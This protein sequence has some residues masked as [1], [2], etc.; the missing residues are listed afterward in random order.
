MESSCKKNPKNEEKGLGSLPNAILVCILSLF[1]TKVV[2]RTSVLCQLWRYLWTEVTAVEFQLPF[3]NQSQPMSSIM[4]RLASPTLLR[5][6][7]ITNHFDTFS[8]RRCCKLACD[9]KVEENLG[10]IGLFFYSSFYLLTYIRKVVCHYLEPYAKMTLTGSSCV[11][12]FLLFLQIAPN[13][14]EVFV[15][16]DYDYITH[17]VVVPEFIFNNLDC[18]NIIRLQGNS[19]EVNLVG[20]IIKN[21]IGLNHH[22][23][24]VYVDDAVE[25]EDARPETEFKLY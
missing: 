2:V 24:R 4:S 14:K 5:F 11:N 12:D 1:P 23:M 17:S 10:E 20:Y 3:S 15:I 7:V 18:V 9:R 25:E 22:Y 16:L 19:D 13:L 6:S 21:A 8:D